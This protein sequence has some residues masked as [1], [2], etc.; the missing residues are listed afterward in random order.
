MRDHPSDADLEAFAHGRLRGD[1]LVVFDSHL[2]VCTQCREAIV[3][4]LRTSPSGA[5]AEGSGRASA[6]AQPASTEDPFADLTL[7]GRY[8]IIRRVAEG[9]MGAI[10]EAVH[11]LIGRTVAIKVLHPSIAHDREIVRR[12]HNE[13]RAAATI[14]H[15]NIVEAIDMGVL[16]DGSPFLVLEFLKGCSLAEELTR[17]GP[18]PVERVLDLATSVGD[19]LSAAHRNR[20]I[21][22]DLKPANIFIEASGRV[23]VIDFGI[24]K[25]TTRSIEG[26][27]V[28]DRTRP[29]M[30][31][32][33]PAYMAPEQFSD[34]ASVTESADI[35]SLGVVIYECLL[36]RQPFR[37]VSV[38]EILVNMMTKPVAS[39]RTERD[40]VPAD[41][42]D[43]VVRALSSE[44]TKRPALD[45]LLTLCRSARARASAPEIR[46][47]DSQ[48]V[49]GIFLAESVAMA[50]VTR[51]LNEATDKPVHFRTFERGIMS[52]GRAYH[53]VVLSSETWRGDEESDALALGMR[54]TNSNPIASALLVAPFRIARAASSLSLQLT[55]DSATDLAPLLAALSADSGVLVHRSMVPT[56]R[57]SFRLDVLSDQLVRLAGARD[58]SDSPAAPLIGRAA[59]LTQLEAAYADAFDQSLAILLH[60]S[61]GVGKTR[62]V[63][64]FADTAR[65]KGA[66]VLH[67]DG[68]STRGLQ[69]PLDLARALE[70]ESRRSGFSAWDHERDAQD[71]EAS[72][73]LPV[74]ARAA[75]QRDLART[76]IERALGLHPESSTHDMVS[77]SQAPTLLVLDDVDTSSRS[78]LECL[79][80]LLAENPRGVLLVGTSRNAP[81]KR[82]DAEPFVGGDARQLEVRGLSLS[83]TRDLARVLAAPG[84]DIEALHRASD[85]NPLFIEQ[86]LAA[87]HDRTGSTATPL[88]PSIE[89]AIQLRLDDLSALEREVTE[90]FAVLDSAASASDIVTLGSPLA[91]EA[92]QQL[93]RKKIL[94]RSA[95]SE[96]G[97]GRADSRYRFASALVQEVAYRALP[98]SARRD[99]HRRA[100]SLLESLRSAD[101]DARAMHLERADLQ[102]DAAA[103]YAKA[104]TSAIRRADATRALALSDRAL[105]VGAPASVAYE[106]HM[107]R[108][109]AFALLGSVRD[110][111][112]ALEAAILSARTDEETA[113]ALSE[114][115]VLRQRLG[116]GRDALEIIGHGIEAAERGKSAEILART[117][118]RRAVMLLYA[119]EVAEARRALIRAEDLVLGHS[120]HPDGKNAHSTHGPSRMLRA[121]LAVWKGQLA[122]ATGDHGERRHAYLAALAIYE[123]IGDSRSAAGA[124]ANLADAYNRVGDYE[125]AVRALTVALERARKIRFRAL[126]GYVLTNLGYASLGLGLFRDAQLHLEA[127][128]SAARDVG[129][130]RL[131][132]FVA[133]YLARAFASAK[134]GDDA[135][136]ELRRASEIAH[137]AGSAA[138]KTSAVEI[139]ANVT[140]A[141]LALS[142]GQIATALTHSELALR[143][144]DQLGGIEE[145]EALVYLTRARVLQLAGQTELSMEVRFRG[146]ARVETMAERFS[147]KDFRDRFLN[148]VP[149]HRALSLRQ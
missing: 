69:D 39:L 130:K 81:S 121:E 21:H 127:A 145:D 67:V 16:E 143:Q 109:E 126:E 66:R 134:R 72:A 79:S 12:F 114:Q 132:S 83:G 78:T 97:V 106:L 103:A 35:F 60:G 37:G 52:G 38:H 90:A 111:E 44:A 64:T 122:A 93:V 65:A 91:A 20:I 140:L 4:H 31:I 22:R 11:T 50:E 42:D 84:V 147:D 49:V 63:S 71:E 94:L 14:G 117:L 139:L 76:R 119:G 107:A 61:A 9:G 3:A 75:R 138:Q 46:R 100:A 149:A 43:F 82:A 115:A 2:D 13:A 92:I 57:K 29:N 118:G 70:A 6:S 68:R 53:C 10:Y 141:E 102:L 23:K 105:A 137:E 26:S 17:L 95:P 19:A 18:L 99:L 86:I 85:G 62:L 5:G 51:L 89:A 55:E 15:P 146:R 28:L 131:E 32:G 101:H 96:P 128:R 24:S 112:T 58:D 45:A 125:E 77:V 8:R 104:A 87:Q 133:L 34:A 142:D 129:D 36:A 47:R 88:S 59:D 135:R 110:E 120:T 144:R 25:F 7:A 56:A 136:R 30:M 40:D 48:L 74:Q 108:A 1:A 124:A 98:T 41:L 80:D 73:S 54:I 123:E 116:D 113:M 33:T 148:D 27:D